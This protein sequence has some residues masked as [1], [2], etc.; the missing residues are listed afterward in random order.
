MDKDAII[1]KIYY[2]EAGYSSIK[3]TWNDAKKIDPSITYD[4][5]KRWKEN[6]IET[7]RQLKGYNSFIADKAYQEFQIDIMFFSD[8]KDSFAGGLLLVDIF[9]KYTQVI[10]V[11]GKTTD[12]ILDALVEGIRLMGGYPEVI[13]SDNE[14]CFS[15]TKIKEY[16]KEHKIKNIITLNHAPV[17]ERQIRTSKDM[18][19]K[20][21]GNTGKP[22]T[23]L[24]NQVLLT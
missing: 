6:N 5:V 13:Y 4:D 1:E 16:Y 15:S 14:A 10:P 24:L 18:M 7:K 20:R 22:W 21:V 23:E 17:A 8:L 2:D 11:H 12:E 3:E 9:S 19:Y